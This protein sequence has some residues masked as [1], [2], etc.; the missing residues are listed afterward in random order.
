[1]WENKN[2]FLGVAKV[3]SR[4]TGSASGTTLRIKKR[5]FGIFFIHHGFNKKK[6]SILVI[7]N[8]DV[9]LCFYIH[10]LY[11]LLFLAVALGFTS[12]TMIFDSAFLLFMEIVHRV[13]IHRGG[14]GGG[15]RGLRLR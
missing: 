2:P 13:F 5:K 6:S 8:L 4:A 14:G 1:V 12:S 7:K 3:I 9:F 11:C 10:F 15:G